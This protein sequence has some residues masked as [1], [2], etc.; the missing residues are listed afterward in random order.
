MPLETF[1]QTFYDDFV[2]SSIIYLI[3]FYYTSYNMDL[4]QSVQPKPSFL[5]NVQ[6]LKENLCNNKQT[7]VI[8]MDFAKAF[9]KVPHKKLIRKLRE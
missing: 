6:D 1:L 8:A 4:E 7:D 9:D 3:F 2:I 5:Q